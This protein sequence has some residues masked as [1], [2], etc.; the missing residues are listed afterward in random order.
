M[1]ALIAC[2]EEEE[3]S[4]LVSLEGSGV[5]IGHCVTTLHALMKVKAPEKMVE[6]FKI[7]MSQRFPK[8]RLDCPHPHPHAKK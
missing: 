6:A 7:A 3:L 5:T 2:D 1:S 4:S 8:A